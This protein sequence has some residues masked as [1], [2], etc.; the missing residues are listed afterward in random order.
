MLHNYSGQLRQAREL[1]ILQ[2]LQQS[3]QLVSTNYM[4]VNIISCTFTLCLPYT[5][6]REVEGLGT[7]TLCILKFLLCYALMP[8]TKPIVYA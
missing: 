5:L 8:N 3:Y 2:P 6:Y 4:L 1:G 7:C